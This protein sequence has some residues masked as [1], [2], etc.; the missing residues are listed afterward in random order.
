MRLPLK[1][2][3][4]GL[5][6]KGLNIFLRGC[7]YTS[8]LRDHYALGLA[9][10]FFE[11]PLDRITGTRI[12]SALPKGLEPWK[13]VRGLDVAKS[14]AYQRAAQIVADKKGIARVHLDAVWWGEREED[15]PIPPASTDAGAGQALESQDRAPHSSAGGGR[16]ASAG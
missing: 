6:R 10:E 7:L 2:R 16:G 9:E 3:H 13:T 1:A 11:L 15:C 5:A 14:A 4:W 8:Y 12:Y